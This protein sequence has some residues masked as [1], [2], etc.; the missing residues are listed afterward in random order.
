MSVFKVTTRCYMGESIFLCPDCNPLYLYEYLFIDKSCFFFAT[1]KDF[2]FTP[3]QVCLI[4]QVDNKYI[5][6]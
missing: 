3:Y 5:F 2:F 1:V 6:F 4:K